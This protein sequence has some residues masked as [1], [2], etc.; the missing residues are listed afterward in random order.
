MSVSD[1]VVSF[2]VLS[3]NFAPFLGEC[4]KSILGQEGEHHFE[5]VLV[6][7]ASTDGTAAILEA[8]RD[9]RLRVFR[10]NRNLGHAATVTEA[11]THSRGKY[12]ARIDGDDKYRPDYLNTAVP[13][14][15]R[16][17]E[18]GLVYG[19]AA[20]VDAG[21][22]ITAERSDRV[23][24]GADHKGNELVALL[25]QNFICAPTVIARRSAWLAC[26]PIPVGLV[27]HDWYFTVMMAR[28]H[29]FYYVNRVIA[30]Y[31]VHGGNYHTRIIRDKTEEPS[32]FALL[33]RVFGE[34][35]SP[36]SLEQAKRRARHRILA[37]H[38]RTL[39]DKYFGMQ[40]N[41]DARRCYWAAMRHTPLL[42]LNPGI[43]R[44]LA[45]TLVGR[46]RYEGGKALIRRAIVRNQ[47]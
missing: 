9:P 3:Y 8:F 32:V 1:P 15:E 21:S 16:Y 12:V 27:F 17:S 44:R 39:A 5:I 46:E 29:E 24:R 34:C 11:L 38:Y 33:D 42:A 36:D 47:P 13:I 18:V 28:Q 2:L 26:L 35:E 4:L 45:A 43:Q 7:D 37:C 31:R 23:H 19:D 6:D 10:R 40:M 14:L 41:E 20:L 22:C 30:D 25:A